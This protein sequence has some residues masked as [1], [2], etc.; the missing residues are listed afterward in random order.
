MEDFQKQFI[1]ALLAYAAQRDVKPQRLCKLSGIDYKALLKQGRLP[2]NAAQINNLWKNAAHLSNDGLFGLHF[3]ESMQLAALG[4]VGQIIQTSNSVGEA[5]SNAG[6]MT[7]LLT[8]IFRM[9]VNHHKKTFT[10]QFNADAKKS[11]ASPSTFRHMADFL[12]VFVVHELDGLLL[13][14]VEPISVQLPYA[15][16]DAAEYARVLR[17]PIKKKTGEL[18]IELDNSMLNLSILTANYEL[19]NYLLGKVQGLIKGEEEAGSLE[20]RIYN[21]LLTNSYLYA[22]SLEAVAANFNISPRNLQRKLKEEGVT[23]I[24]IVE[25][26]RKTLAEHY[27]Q[28]GNYQVKDIA[29]ILGYNEPSAFLRAFKRWTGITPA[30]YQKTTTG[31]K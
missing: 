31:D 27:L 20:A 17:G 28:S 3:G 25:S 4:V 21:Y 9:Q 13:Q 16:E 18:A 8:D 10:V 29:Y 5:L 12:A 7:P 24:Q 19:Q 6:A 23:F 26:V 2:L 1:L 30:A 22:L 15:V 11:A 14:K